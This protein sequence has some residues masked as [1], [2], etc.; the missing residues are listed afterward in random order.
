MKRNEPIE[1]VTTADVTTVHVGV[2]LSAVA[3]ILRENDFRHIPVVEGTRPVGLISATDIFKLVY[4]HDGTDQR[5]AAAILD[6]EHTVAGTMS[7]DLSTLPS[8]ATV[9]DAAVML[10]SGGFGSILVVD[11]EGQLVGV[12]TTVDLIRYLRDQL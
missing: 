10:S 4:D 8:T 7:T 12:V 9:Y 3:G 5:M 1:T 6:H 2:P 11:E